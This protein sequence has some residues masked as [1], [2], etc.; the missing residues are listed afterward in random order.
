MG[1]RPALT[2]TL[3]NMGNLTSK[4]EVQN[5]LISASVPGSWARTG[6][7][8]AEDDEAVLLWSS[9]ERFE[10]LYCGVWP[11]W[12]ATLTTRTT[13]P[14]YS[15]RFVSLPSMFLTLKFR[16]QRGL[17]LGVQSGQ[18]RGRQAA[19]RKPLRSITRI[20]VEGR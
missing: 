10:P 14:L 16:A 5:C 6:S 8:E 19:I 12:L 15:E 11:H 9:Y 1:V 20:S 2:S 17:L 7:R 13:F 3:E 18:G 4:R